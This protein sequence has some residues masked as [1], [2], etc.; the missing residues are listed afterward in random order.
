MLVKAQVLRRQESVHHMV[1]KL[2]QGNQGAV[3]ASHQFGEEL[4]VHIINA[5]GLR[6]GLQPLSIQALPGGHVKIDIARRCGGER[7]QRQRRQYPAAGPPLSRLFLLPH[8][9]PPVVFFRIF[10]R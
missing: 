5:A 10:Q 3:L 8:A 2:L 4:P 1:R 9:R 7:Q 6:Q